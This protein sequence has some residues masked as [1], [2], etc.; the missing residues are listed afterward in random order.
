MIFQEAQASLSPRQ[1][2]ASLITE[3]YRINRVPPK[4]RYPVGELLAMVGLSPDL[5][6]KYP[7]QLS[8]GQAR[9]VGIARALSLR[10]EFVVA[11][12]PTAGLDLS[13][14][15]AIL[16][17]IRDLQQRLGLTFI[18]ITHNVNL[19]GYMAH[20]IAVM[21]LGSLVE[22]GPT[23]A[24]F[25]SPAHPYSL[26]LLS[27]TPRPDPRESGS[28]DCWCRARFR[29]P[30]IRRRAAG[31]TRDAGSPRRDAGRRRRH[32]KRSAAGTKSPA[33]FGSA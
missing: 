31:F 17:L 33:I 14:A 6:T 11:D 4:E 18:I 22:I 8:G 29:A 24:V 5:A 21:Y 32:W 13:A 2:V 3:P 12:E 16:N 26:G 15:A 23:E 30:G 27:L 25:D 28:T 10:P 9:R 20:R 19:I 7:H 1:R